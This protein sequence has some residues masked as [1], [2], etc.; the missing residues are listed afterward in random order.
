MTSGKGISRRELLSGL[1]GMAALSLIGSR[2]TVRGQVATNSWPQFGPDNANTGYVPQHIG[3]GDEV[4]EQWHYPELGT[5]SSVQVTDEMVIV[6]DQAGDVV[7]ID[8]SDATEQWRF[9]T[10]NRATCEA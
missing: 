8:R 4:V 3:P 1:G 9:S 5:L 10:H 7:A 2:N 6:G